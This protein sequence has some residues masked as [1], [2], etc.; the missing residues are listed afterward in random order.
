MTRADAEWL[1]ALALRLRRAEE[2]LG[3]TTLSEEQVLWRLTDAQ[4]SLAAEIRRRRAL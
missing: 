1:D 4:S 3:S 2:A